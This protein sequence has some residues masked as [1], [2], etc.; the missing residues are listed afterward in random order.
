MAS[1]AKGG[2]P[3]KRYPQELKDRA[4]RMVNETIQAQG[5]SRSS[6]DGC[7]DSASGNTA[8]VR[9]AR[10]QVL[11]AA[12]TANPLRFGN[13]RPEPPKL[14]MVAWINEPVKE[15]IQTGVSFGMTGSVSGSVTNG[16]L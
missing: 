15:P 12:Y 5:G 2:T 6:A 14:P 11:E 7:A 4:V 1:T 13:R 8:Q 3:P 16:D 10:A 9:M